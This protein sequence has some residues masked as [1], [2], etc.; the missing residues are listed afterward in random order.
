[1]KV[2]MPVAK[3]TNYVATVMLGIMMMVTVADVTLRYLFH[4]PIIGATEITEMM[5]LS[6]AAL[7]LAWAAINREQLKV[8]ILV[9]KLSKQKQ[10][11]IDVCTFIPSAI[12]CAILTWRTVLEAYALR[13]LHSSSS[14][15]KIP[16]FPFYMILAWGC[17]TTC[18]VLVILIIH[19]ISS[20][21]K[22]DQPA[23]TNAAKETVK[24]E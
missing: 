24:H 22:K 17:L 16:T 2:M 5:I 4:A 1:M 23:T 3:I 8:D 9:A 6:I 7:G 21:V 14:L 15:L 18:I 20:L 19:D 10:T 11:L 13:D 12:L